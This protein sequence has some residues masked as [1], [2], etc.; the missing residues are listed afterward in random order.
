MTLPKKINQF[1]KVVIKLM[2]RQKEIKNSKGTFV[3]DGVIDKGL[4]RIE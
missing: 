3:N 2:A 1:L 4:R